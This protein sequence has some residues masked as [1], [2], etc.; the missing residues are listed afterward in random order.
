MGSYLGHWQIVDEWRY[1][2]LGKRP[3]A[4]GKSLFVGVLG[5]EVRP[6]MVNPTT[7]KGDLLRTMENRPLLK[8][9]LDDFPWL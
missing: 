4:V 7:K 8:S 9:T 1:F 2:D 3:V 6:N 5:T